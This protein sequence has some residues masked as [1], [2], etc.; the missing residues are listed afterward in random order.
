MSIIIVGVIKCKRNHNKEEKSMNINFHYYAVKALAVNAGFDEDDAQLISSY[1][2]FVDDF[3]TYRLLYFKDVPNYAQY[4]ATKLPYGWA[5]NPVT[6]GF[7]SFFDYARLS[8]E[9][10]Q[11]RILIPFHFIPKRDLS[12]VP[13]D[14]KEYRVHPVN[15]SENSLLQGL[16]ED[17]KNAYRDFANRESIIRI[18]TLMHILADTYAHQR[19]SGFWN[20]EN[21]TYLEDAVDNITDKNITN[22]YSP[23]YY[24]Y[25]PSIGHPNV[26][27]A[28]DDSNVSFTIIQKFEPHEV[29][30]YKAT[31]SRSNVLEYLKCSKVILNYLRDCKSQEPISDDEW[32]LLSENLEKGFLISNKNEEVFSN[33]WHSIFPDIVFK[34]SKKNLLTSQFTIENLANQEKIASDEDISE[35]LMTIFN[36]LESPQYL[37]SGDNEDFFKYNVIADRIRKAVDPS[38][39]GDEVI[40][41]FKEEL[42]LKDH[43][44]AEIISKKEGK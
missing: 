40:L 11:K 44:V 18:G 4:L 32:Q 43:H 6:T 12:Y 9:R 27:T 2:Q 26:S 1:S 21:H 33:H 10:N 28:P 39:G 35:N 31:Y 8:T 30:P 17:A 25:M 16:L 37:I 7:N 38:Y 29:F 3:D 14:R 36:N 13:E 23:N 19:F 41:K 15:L 5:F 34:Y 24:Y 20:W 22:S 42:E